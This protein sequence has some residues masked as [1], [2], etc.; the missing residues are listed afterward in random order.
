[1]SIKGVPPPQTIPAFAQNQSRDY[2][3]SSDGDISLRSSNA[4]CGS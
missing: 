4:V 2:R 1:M 3:I